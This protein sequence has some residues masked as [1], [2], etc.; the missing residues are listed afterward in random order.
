[1]LWSPAHSSYYLSWKVLGIVFST[2]NTSTQESK[3]RSLWA[4]G[5]ILV[6]KQFQ[7]SLR[8]TMRLDLKQRNKL[9]SCYLSENLPVFKFAEQF[10]L[11]LSNDFI[12]FWVSNFLFGKW[13]FNTSHSHII[14]FK[15]EHI[16]VVTSDYF[17]KEFL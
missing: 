16:W 4:G 10:L 8:Y 9:K 11:L 7:S 6:Y 1:M 17:I 15:R 3:A 2:F 14:S 5:S 12:L 13:I